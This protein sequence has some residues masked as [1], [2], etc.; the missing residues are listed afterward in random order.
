MVAFYDEKAVTALL[1]ADSGRT[2]STAIRSEIESALEERDFNTDPFTQVKWDGFKR[3][4]EEIK[5]LLPT[6]ELVRLQSELQR[7]YGI[8]DDRR[9]VEL[10]EQNERCD[11]VDSLTDIEWAHLSHVK[12]D[13]YLSSEKFSDVIA[14]S[15]EVAERLGGTHDTTLLDKT[16]SMKLNKAEAHYKLGQFAK[17]KFEV[18]D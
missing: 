10:L 18:K 4:L 8:R 5:D 16:C 7:A 14:I 3:T 6:Y 9:I 2:E 15:D 12:S 11:W 17:S 13:A 1:T